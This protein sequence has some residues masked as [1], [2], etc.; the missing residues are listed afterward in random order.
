MSLMLVKLKFANLV[1]VITGVDVRLVLFVG[2]ITN[3]A[4]S[5]MESPTSRLWCPPLIYSGCA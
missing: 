2:S 4:T 3:L 1:H 5:D